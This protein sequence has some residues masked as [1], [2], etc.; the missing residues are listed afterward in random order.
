MPVYRTGRA[1]GEGTDTVARKKERTDGRVKEEPIH[2]LTH[3]WRNKPKMKQKGALEV[4]SDTRTS[5]SGDGSRRTA[6]RG[7]GKTSHPTNNN[8]HTTPT[9]RASPIDDNTRFRTEVE[10]T[11]PNPQRRTWY[12]GVLNGMRHVRRYGCRKER[13]DGPKNEWGVK[14]EEM[15]NE[16]THTKDH[17]WTKQKGAT[18]EYQTKGMRKRERRCSSNAATAGETP[19]S[20]G[21]RATL[22]LG[23]NT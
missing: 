21:W 14:E 2:E 19:Q 15:S 7:I 16:L 13:T 20:A 10:C 23:V 1:A 11:A 3:P 17:P 12:A 8:L 6:P 18:A 4:T 9:E 5:P 22:S